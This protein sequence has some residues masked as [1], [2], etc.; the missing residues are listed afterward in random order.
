ML[1]NLFLI[2]AQKSGTSSLAA[3]LGEHSGIFLTSPKEPSVFAID[4]L[5]SIEDVYAPTLRGYDREQYILDASTA[6]LHDEKALRLINQADS[7]AKIIIILRSP[8]ER[9]KSAFLH[10]KKR[11]DDFRTAKEVFL[12]LP[13]SQADILIEE[14]RRIDSAIKCRLIPKFEFRYIYR[15]ERWNFHYIRN[16]LY[17][18]LLKTVFDI[19]GRDRVLVLP[20]E[21][22]TADPQKTM[23]RIAAFLDID[24]MLFPT[25][26]K[27]EN[28]T[29]VPSGI[30]P[31]LRSR[32]GKFGRLWTKISA[33]TAGIDK[34]TDLELIADLEG[35]FKENTKKL[36]ELVGQDFYTIWHY[37]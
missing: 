32:K 22:Y 2:G 14:D 11:F 33:K 12:D 17:F 5:Q 10:C 26:P 25:K 15:N 9:T 21:P 18:D 19:F 1:P 35:L 30:Y 24:Q 16:S 28:P 27:A 31:A 34:Q 3:H 6:Y 23:A 36:S 20:F 13:D 8:S 37:D 7:T 4:G 29:Y